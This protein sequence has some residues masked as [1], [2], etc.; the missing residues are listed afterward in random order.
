MADPSRIAHARHKLLQ[1]IRA[2]FH[3]HGYIEVSTP[4]RIRTPALEDTITA[5]ESSGSYLR[6]SPELHMKRLLAEGLEKI[7]Q[8]GPCF[9]ASEQGRLHHTEFTMLEWYEAGKDYLDM[10]EFISELISSLAREFQ[11]NINELQQIELETAFENWSSIS[12]WEALATD[13]FEDE[14]VS[15]IEANL[16]NHILYKFPAEHAAMSRIHTDIRFCE[17]W[18]LYLNGIEIA[19]CYTELTNQEE[20]LKRFNQTIEYRKNNNLKNYP[21]DMQFID[22][23]DTIPESA[24]VALGIERLLMQLTNKKDISE[25]THFME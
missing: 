2:F 4:I 23:M 21:V 12:L 19:N 7:Y 15:A 3:D 5:I 16:N 8:I 9:R 17:R 18:E 14:L 10:M 1:A 24:G 22:A 20:Q 6:T 11:F 13:N 25:V